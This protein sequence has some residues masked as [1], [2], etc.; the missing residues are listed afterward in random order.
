[1]ALENIVGKRVEWRW[2]IAFGFGLVHGFGFSFAL[3]ETMQFA[4]RI[5]LPRC[6]HSTSAWSLG[7]CSCSRCSSLC[8][9]GSSRYVVEERMGTIILSALVAHTGWHWMIER[10]DKLRQFPWPTLS[11]AMLASA[12]RWLIVMVFLAGLVWLVP[13]VLRYWTERSLVGKAEGMEPQMNTD[14]HG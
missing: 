4:G 5:S 9:R 12:M 1:M 8:S 13:G 3:R 6:S 14:E 2:I 7:N 10:G 11:A